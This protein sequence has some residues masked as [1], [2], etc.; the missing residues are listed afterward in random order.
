MTVGC[1]SALARI[2]LHFADGH[3]GHGGCEN[4]SINLTLS[5]AAIKIRDCSCGVVM[6]KGCVARGGVWRPSSKVWRSQRFAHDQTSARVQQSRA[7]VPS[8]QG[9]R[10]PTSPLSH[11]SSALQYNTANPFLCAQL[12][13]SLSLRTIAIIFA[14]DHR[15]VAPS[16]PA[17]TFPWGGATVLLRAQ[18]TVPNC[19]LPAR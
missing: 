4:R 6:V 18:A 14:H 16:P 8:C 1:G 10:V 5:A 9:P 2:T 15:S 19:V 13:L 17:L 3:S 11:D 12:L 7:G